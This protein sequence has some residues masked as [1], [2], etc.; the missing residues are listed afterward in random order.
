MKN[1]RITNPVIIHECNGLAI[2]LEFKYY[3]F[4]ITSKAF[5]IL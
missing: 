2:G 4:F 5:D 1:K 3:I